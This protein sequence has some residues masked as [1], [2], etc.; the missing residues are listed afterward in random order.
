MIRRSIQQ[1][2]RGADAP[3]CFGK[4]QG[5]PTLRA[6][7][8]TVGGTD[9][10]VHKKKSNAKNEGGCVPTLVEAMDTVGAH[11]AR[12]TFGYSRAIA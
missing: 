7:A 4:Q 8:E 6:Y 10:R 5:R 12:S 3:A 11:V 9:Q 2:R 1:H